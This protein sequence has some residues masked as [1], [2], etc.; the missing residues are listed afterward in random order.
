LLFYAL[1][2]AI[3]FFFGEEWLNQFTK[4]ELSLNLITMACS[5]GFDRVAAGVDYWR[6]SIGL[7]ISG[8]KPALY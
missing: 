4:K 7:F 8:F 3:A 2:L 5:S 1:V 6:A